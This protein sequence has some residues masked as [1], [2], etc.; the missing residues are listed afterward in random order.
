M[1][2]GFQVGWITPLSSSSLKSLF[3]A[4]INLGG[5]GGSGGVRFSMD[6]PTVAGGESCDC[7][8]RSS[9]DPASERKAC[10]KLLLPAPLCDMREGSL[11][12]RAS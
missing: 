5:E 10:P 12:G 8:P 4:A 9:Q 6:E 2:R 11:C 3:L 1:G 7:P